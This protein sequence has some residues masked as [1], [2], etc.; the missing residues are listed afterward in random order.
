M[1]HVI[2]YIAKYNRGLAIV[3][4]GA[5]FGFGRGSDDEPHDICTNVESASILWGHY[6]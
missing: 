3:V 2:E 6:F 5:E 1:A 4:E